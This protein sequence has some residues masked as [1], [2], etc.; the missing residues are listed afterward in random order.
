MALDSRGLFDGHCRCGGGGRG[1]LGR[2]VP[3]EAEARG[4]A[5]G[6]RGR[7][8]PLGGQPSRLPPTRCD[9]AV[10]PVASMKRLLVGLGTGT[11]C[12]QAGEGFQGAETE[13]LLFK[14]TPSSRS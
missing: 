10:V 1:S 5:V 14:E 11:Y 3:G 2:V 7:R 4:L 13:G 8:L 9:G 12:R 6:A